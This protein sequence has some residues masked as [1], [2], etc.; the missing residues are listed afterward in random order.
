[1]L[2]RA[3]SML[4]TG[5]LVSEPLSSPRE[6]ADAGGDGSPDANRKSSHSASG[7]GMTTAFWSAGFGHDRL[8]V[9]TTW[10]WTELKQLGLP[11][12][13]KG[14]SAIRRSAN[15][16][17][18]YAACPAICMIAESRRVADRSL[19]V[20]RETARSLVPPHWSWLAVQQ[21]G[22]QRGPYGPV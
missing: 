14:I 7:L 6:A 1:M 18:H 10:L 12:E 15:R 21:P 4:A 20:A 19:T 16:A 9:A 2:P 5:V 13:C 17:D 22:N 3:R 8:P 11:C